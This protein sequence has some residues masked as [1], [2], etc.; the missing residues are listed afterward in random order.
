[1][2]LGSVK[3][4]L[5]ERVFRLESEKKSRKGGTSQSDGRC[6]SM[7]KFCDVRSMSHYPSVTKCG[8]P[9]AR[10]GVNEQGR[11]SDEDDDGGR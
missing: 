11:E 3:G 6:Q 7:Q 5:I 8:I 1:M 10:C 4:S 2:G 9:G